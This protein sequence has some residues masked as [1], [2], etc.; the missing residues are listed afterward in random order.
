MVAYIEHE[1]T[2]YDHYGIIC[3]RNNGMIIENTIFMDYYFSIA[4]K[5]PRYI[6]I[7]TSIT[8]M[9]KRGGATIKTKSLTFLKS[10]TNIIDPLIYTSFYKN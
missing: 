6:A 4:N 2:F 7:S 9:S 3:S 1:K 8:A 5:G 10:D